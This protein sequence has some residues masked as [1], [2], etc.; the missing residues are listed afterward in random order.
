MFCETTRNKFQT[1]RHKLHAQFKKT[2]K[3][4]SPMDTNYL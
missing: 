2:L 1:S 3:S 4:T